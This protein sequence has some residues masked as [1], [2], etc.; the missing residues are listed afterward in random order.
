MKIRAFITHKK[1]EHFNDCQDRFSINPDTKSVAVSDGMSQSYQQ[2]I[3]AELLVNAYTENPGWVPNHTSVKALSPLWLENVKLFVQKLIDS[4]APQY[5]V[6]MNQNA[7]AQQKSAG[8]TFCGIRFSGYNWSGYV[9]GDSCLLVISDD[10][11]EELYTSQVGDEFD[12]HPDYFDSNPS[13]CGKGDPLQIEGILDESKIIMIVS[14]PL[15]DFLNK[16]RKLGHEEDYIGQLLR[17]NNHD[18]FEELVENW[19]EEKDAMHNDDTTLIVIEYDNSTELNL[20]YSDNIKAIIEKEV[21]LQE[22]NGSSHKEKSEKIQRSVPKNQ[23]GSFQTILDAELDP[24]NEL[25]YIVSNEEFVQTGI[26]FIEKKMVESDTSILKSICSN[27][28][29][30]IREALTE[31]YNFYFNK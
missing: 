4:N 12:N 3:W 18:E 24:M 6:I 29:A 10:K 23:S 13:K 22:Q 26:V 31:L 17:I 11:I 30:I 15:S 2:K 14:D 25:N 8:A 9:L 5:L 20:V 7:I 27:D 1:A 28:D 21:Q 19:R 16:K